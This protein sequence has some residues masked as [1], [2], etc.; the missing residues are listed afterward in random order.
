MPLLRAPIDPATGDQYETQTD[1]TVLGWGVLL[2]A[3]VRARGAQSRSGTARSLPDS[4]LLIT[5]PIIHCTHQT[6]STPWPPEVNLVS[7]DHHEARR[8]TQPPE[9][10]LPGTASI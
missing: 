2:A 6:I 1:V 9:A 5:A 3:P 7:L 4:S 10:G 8:L